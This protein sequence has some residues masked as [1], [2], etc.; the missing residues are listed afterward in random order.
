VLQS[1]P[2]VLEYQPLPTWTS[3]RAD[4]EQRRIHLT[5]VRILLYKY[6]IGEGV[7]R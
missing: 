3:L 4:D 5:G 7:H 6:A 2:E 1:A